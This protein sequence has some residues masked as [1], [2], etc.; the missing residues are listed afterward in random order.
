MSIKVN[1]AVKQI[2]DHAKDTVDQN[3]TAAIARGD[4]KGIDPK[5]VDIS[6]IITL[7]KS[8]IEQAYLQSARSLDAAISAELAMAKKKGS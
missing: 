2:I 6:S 8:S 5:L 1:R 4:I 7:A 3:L